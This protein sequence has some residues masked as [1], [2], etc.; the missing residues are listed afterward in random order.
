ME[1][2]IT[3]ELTVDEVTKIKEENE[4]LLAEVKELQ[5]ELKKLEDE[6]DVLDKAK[7]VQEAAEKERLA[8]LAKLTE[9]KK[10]LEK[11]INESELSVEKYQKAIERLKN[12]NKNTKLLIQKEE[13]TK[14]GL[15]EMLVIKRGQRLSI[16]PVTKK[17]FD[18]VCK[19][20]GL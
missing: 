12:E 15:E 5:E 17:H 3:K 18:I 16:Q 10:A 19:M 4:T 7:I 11:Q 6:A 1:P 2:T 20:G 8:Q 13:D 9:E 14:K